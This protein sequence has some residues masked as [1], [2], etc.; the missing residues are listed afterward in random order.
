MPIA[1]RNPGVI[2]M[3]AVTT[4]G[5]NVKPRPGAFGHFGTGI[6]FAIA[7]ILRGGGRITIWAG[8]TPHVFKTK[9]KT[10]RG[11]DFDLVWMDR[12]P[13]L[14]FTTQL[15]KGWEP[16]MVLRELGCNALDEG[17][18]FKPIDAGFD[19][20]IHTKV[21]DAE[22]TTIVVD[23]PKLDEV[24]AEREDIFAVGEPLYV[25]DKVR[26]LPGPSSHLYYRGVRVLKLEH[27][28]VFRYDVLEAMTLTEDRTLAGSWNADRLIRDAILACTDEDVLAGALTCGRNKYESGLDFSPEYEAVEPSKAFIDVVLN[29]RERRDDGLL[30]SARSRVQKQIRTESMEYVGR[31]STRYV[32]DAFSEA[33]SALEDL[34]LPLGDTKVLLVDE[35]PGEARSRTENGRIYVLRSLL[36]EDSRTI[37]LEIARRIVDLAGHIYAD[38]V[39]AMLLPLL[40]EQHRVLKEREQRREEAA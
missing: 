39:T 28:S 20:A 3:A 7:T 29:A 27:Q 23:W 19:P 38:D 2:D 32:E 4:M 16:W 18:T 33:V 36:N 34:G 35:L 25:T 26:F 9:T 31:T 5:V 14:G 1:F 6:K 22:K 17:G 15:G 30:P 21:L 11:E 12:S 10:I 37:G 13:P 24:Y 8:L 40:L